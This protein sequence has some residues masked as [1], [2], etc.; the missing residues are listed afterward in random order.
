MVPVGREGLSPE[1]LPPIRLRSTSDKGQWLWPPLAQGLWDPFGPGLWPAVLRDGGDLG[2]RGCVALLVCPRPRTVTGAAGPAPRGPAWLSPGKALGLASDP[3]LLGVEGS[4]HAC[5]LAAGLGVGGNQAASWGPPQAPP[6]IGTRAPSG[7]HPCPEPRA[8]RP[9][10]PLSRAG[11]PAPGC[12]LHPTCGR[13]SIQQS[14][15]P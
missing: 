10:L 8:G 7:G 14:A 9:P 3:G 13:A 2:E 5:T 11:P 6:T 1:T 4:L 15:G 12:S